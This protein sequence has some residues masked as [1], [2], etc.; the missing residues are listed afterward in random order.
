MSLYGAGIVLFVL[1]WINSFATLQI[2]WGT[3]WLIVGLILGVIGVIP[4][5]IIAL[6]FK[7]AWLAVSLLV[8]GIIVTLGLRFLGAYAMSKCQ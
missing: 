1:L 2:F 6:I 8:I 7:G 5:A 4:L 3:F